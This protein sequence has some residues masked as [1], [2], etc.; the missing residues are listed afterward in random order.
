[1]AHQ[2]IG[3]P[4]TDRS[5]DHLNSFLRGEISACE[6][7][8]MAIAKLEDEPFRS[9]LE[10][11]LIS[12]ELRCD[13]LRRRIRLLGGTPSDSSGMWGTFA[14]LIEG[15]AKAFGPRAAIAALE[16]GEDHGLADFK[17]DVTDL[18]TET[19]VFVLTHLLPEQEKTHETMSKLKHSF[20]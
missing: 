7:Y 19:R 14:K 18:D 2:T 5:I 15:S 10:Q 1:M 8:R 17:R 6:T 13:G 16:S 4:A 12:H 11:N 3:I 9:E 20:H